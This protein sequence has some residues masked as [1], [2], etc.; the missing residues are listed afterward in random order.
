MGSSV[1]PETDFPRV[2]IMVDNAVMPADE[3]MAALT[4][5][6]E[7]AMKDIPVSSPTTPHVGTA[8]RSGTCGARPSGG[9]AIPCSQ[10][11]M[12]H[13]SGLDGSC[14]S[15]CFS[16][17][18]GIGVGFGDVRSTA[19]RLVIGWRLAETTG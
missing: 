3:M 18:Q 14:L 9:W 5:L 6:I 8:K 13:E 19:Y 10:E 7:E 16:R 4:R 15:G 2:V 1:F 12:N 11:S 17:P